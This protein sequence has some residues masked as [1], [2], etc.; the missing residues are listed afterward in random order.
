MAYIGKIPGGTA[1]SNRTLDSM[2][3][4][5]STN[6]LTLSETPNSVMDVAIYCNGV[7]QRPGTEYT[8]AGNTI[9]FTST[10]ANL[11]LIHI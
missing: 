5:G 2:T 1:I 7:M 8:L 11:S 4:D 9:T 3:G 10:P 6:T